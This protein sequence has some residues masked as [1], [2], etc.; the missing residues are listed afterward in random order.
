MVLKCFL[1]RLN[2]KIQVYLCT[3]HIKNCFFLKS[4]TFYVSGIISIFTDQE[5]PSSASLFFRLWQLLHVSSRIR[6]ICIFECFF[7]SPLF[8]VNMICSTVMS[9]TLV[10]SFSINFLQFIIGRLLYRI[11]VTKDY[12]VPF[13]VFFTLM[14]FDTVCS[15]IRFTMS[16]LDT[17]SF[18]ILF[19]SS[20]REHRFSNHLIPKGDCLPA[21]FLFMDLV[22][23]S[24][25]RTYDYFLFRTWIS[26]AFA[27]LFCI[28]IL[29]SLLGESL[30]NFVVQ[31]FSPRWWLHANFDELLFKTFRVQVVISW[32]FYFRT[33]I[34]DGHCM[35]A[36]YFISH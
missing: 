34:T 23:K 7:S 36:L 3:L 18:W 27:W 20:R 9:F 25:Y 16:A 19:T 13:I 21:W 32:Q 30:D 29:I 4:W 15:L 14:T 31:D 33:R 22:P 26:L 11:I 6:K 35:P 5:I 10:S 24:L 28:C 8:P 2:P 17:S 12:L 1:N